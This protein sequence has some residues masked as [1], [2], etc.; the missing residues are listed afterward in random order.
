MVAIRLA[1]QQVTQEYAWWQRFCSGAYSLF[2]VWLC[3]KLSSVAKHVRRSP[4]SLKCWCTYMPHRWRT[5][6]FEDE[7]K[8][9]KSHWTVPLPSIM[10]IFVGNDANH[11]FQLFTTVWD[12]MNWQAAVSKHKQKSKRR[13]LIDLLQSTRPVIQMDN[14]RLLFHWQDR[15]LFLS[16]VGHAYL[17]MTTILTLLACNIFCAQ[18]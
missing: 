14:L 3:R 11:P 17:K 12:V 6:K 2:F 8:T 5:T 15:C 9:L 7:D 1:S 16:A 13:K 4:Q 10:S 18:R